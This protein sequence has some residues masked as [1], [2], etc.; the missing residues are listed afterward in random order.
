MAQSGSVPIFPDHAVALWK[1]NNPNR[2]GNPEWDG[3]AFALDDPR[4]P[5][6]IRESASAL[7]RPGSEL[8]FVDTD[9]GGEWWLMCGDDLI[10]AFWL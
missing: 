3:Q 5:E 6:P 10:E 4:I 9:M 7:Y 8:Y 2:C 1:S